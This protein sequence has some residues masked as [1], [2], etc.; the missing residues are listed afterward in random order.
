MSDVR[1]MSVIFAGECTPNEFFE[2]TAKAT[3]TV[4]KLF[5]PLGASI[6]MQADRRHDEFKE[7]IK[8][9]QTLAERN[10]EK[11]AEMLETVTGQITHAEEQMFAAFT[12]M[13]EH[14][15]TEGFKALTAANVPN[16]VQVLRA[17]NARLKTVVTLA[18]EV[19]GNIPEEVITGENV[20]EA[21][22]I[23]EM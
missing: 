16:Q 4:H 17:E 21:V 5:G 14:T 10:P 6:E 19:E 20:I 7:S 22:M 15:V 12:H 1:P 11:A 9:I 23:D 8:V 3:E 13:V 2:F 18:A